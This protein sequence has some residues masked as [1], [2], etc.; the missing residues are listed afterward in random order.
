M[1]SL[2]PAELVA[3][4]IQTLRPPGPESS[5]PQLADVDVPGRGRARIQFETLRY[6]H[7]KTFYWIWSPVRA[8]PI[9]EFVVPVP[10]PGGCFTCTYLLPL[11][12]GSRKAVCGRK[13][14]PFAQDQPLLA[15]VRYER[16]PGVDDDIERLLGFY[17]L[18]PRNKIA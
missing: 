18:S 13:D 4:A 9:G 6:R 17:G 11:A 3:E 12:S 14:K 1:L 15:C 7:G 2:V 10:P 16:E 5:I 8:D